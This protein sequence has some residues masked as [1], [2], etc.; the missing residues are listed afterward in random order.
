[1]ADESNVAGGEYASEI[2][3]EQMAEA[4]AM[5]RC[6]SRAFPVG[7]G[8]FEDVQ[9]QTVIERVNLEVDQKVAE[10]TADELM[11]RI[12]NAAN[13]AELEKTKS[14][15]KASKDNK[16][17]AAYAKKLGRLNNAAVA[18]PAPESV[19]E[20]ENAESDQNQPEQA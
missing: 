15:V 8:N 6:L 10:A 19:T 12:E 3:I 14:D 18:Q 4:R 17:V 9:E 1:M 11:D 20:T 5:R 7:M 16:Y 13:V 2:K